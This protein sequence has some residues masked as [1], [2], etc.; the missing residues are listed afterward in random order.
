V[1]EEFVYRG[2][3]TETTVPAMLA[4]IHRH[5]VPGVM[6]FTRDV[7]TKRVCFL[8]GDV[9]FATSSERSESLGDY[10]VQQGRIT[11]AQFDV[12]CDE[13]A[14]SPGKRHGT[15]L[16]QLGFLRADEL[17]EAVRE[18]I[19]SILWSLFN[20][21]DGNVTFRVGRFRE[22]EVYKIK[23]STPRAIIEGCKR[24]TDAKAVTARL[25]GRKA[26]LSARPRPAHLKGLRLETGEQQLLDLVDGQTLLVQLCERGPFPPGVNA[27]ILYGFMELALVGRNL[28]GSQG[29]RIQVRS[30]DEPGA[31]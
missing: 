13:L 10:L 18:Q 7:E 3:L 12:S 9:I 28:E 23:I 17:G 21:V 24:I 11:Q 4:T 26:V 19:Y 15:I 14:R 6:E 27:R 2:S 16:V 31:A 8:D 5:R 20:W 25:G 30:G 22:D 1:E 29:I